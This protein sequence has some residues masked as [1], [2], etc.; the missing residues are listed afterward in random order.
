[1]GT[2]RRRLAAIV[3]A[4]IAAALLFVS[5]ST[6]ITAPPVAR[7]V[8]GEYTPTALAVCGNHACVV[9]AA[10]LVK[11]WG[12]NGFGQLG[13]GTMVDRSTPVTVAGVSGATAVAVGIEYSCALISGGTVRCWGNNLSGQ[14]GG[15]GGIGSLTPVTVCAVGETPPC[16]GATALTGVTRIRAAGRHTCVDVSGG[17]MRCW[18]DN[19]QGQLGDGTFINRPVPVV[20]CLSGAGSGCPALSGGLVTTGAFGSEGFTCAVASSIPVCWGMNNVGQLGDGTMGADRAIAA[21]VCDSGSGPMCPSI[22]GISDLSL[23]S[24]HACVRQSDAVKCWGFNNY[25]QLGNGGFTNSA[26]PVAACDLMSATG[27]GGTLNGISSL[28]LGEYHSCVTTNS[29]TAAC[30]GQDFAGQLG[31]GTAGGS[32]AVPALVCRGTPPS[33]CANPL[34]DLFSAGAGGNSHHCTRTFDDAVKCWGWGGQS[35][36]GNNTTV[37]SAVPVCVYSFGDCDTDGDALDDVWE[38]TGDLDDDGTVEVDLP[39]MGADGLV[40]DLF[41]EI[42]WMDCAVAGSDCAPGHDDRMEPLALAAI[43]TNYWCGPVKIVA[44]LDAGP[45]SIMNPTSV[46]CRSRVVQGMAWGVLSHGGPTVHTSVGDRILTPDT[47]GPDRQNVFHLTRMQ[48]AVDQEAGTSNFTTGWGELPGDET[49]LG[50]GVV[51]YPRP[52]TNTERWQAQTA[53]FIHEMGHN[54]DLGH[55]GH[56]NLV[57]FKPNHLSVMNY[58]FAGMGVPV[59]NGA[60]HQH[61]E[62]SRADFDDLSEAALPEQA[63]LGPDPG[64]VATGAYPTRVLGTAWICENGGGITTPLFQAGVAFDA[65]SDVDFNCSGTEQGAPAGSCVDMLD[66]DG[67]L[68][69]DQY[70]PDCTFEASVTSNVGGGELVD[71]GP[72]GQTL[73]GSDDYAILQFNGASIGDPLALYPAGAGGAPLHGDGLEVIPLPDA[74]GDTLIDAGE[75]IAG[76]NPADADSDDDG[77]E[78]GFE[79]GSVGSLPLDPNSDD[80]GCSDGEEAGAVPSQGGRRNPNFQYDFYDVNAS[81]HVNAVDIGLVRSHFNQ[82]TGHPLYSAVYDRSVGVASWAPGAPNGVINAVDI[83]LARVSFNH[84]CQAPP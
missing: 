66:N 71:A 29:A 28:G 46:D 39:A 41:V 77:L 81:Q 19:N 36:L 54:L 53:L 68:F 8:A 34:D 45:A 61:W 21:R 82:N 1:M 13:D 22:G 58:T 25:G 84:T 78:D 14:L 56:E 50:V 23:G 83:N 24:G 48:H 69:P 80:D 70:D 33:P 37:S 2:A 15:S 59:N 74:D 42:D 20:V 52:I 4:S 7:A 9:T 18:G 12:S 27:C 40:K 17:Q 63:G 79:V 43:I 10:G 49:W 64:A 73:T 5:P 55:G 16:S 31:D 75:L 51:T 35:S 62:Y 72:P 65:R 47:R 38:L 11:C 30:W 32:R 44:H 26:L 67:D 57:N 76:T 6:Q 3:I 60:V